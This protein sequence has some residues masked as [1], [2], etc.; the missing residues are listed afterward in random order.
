MDIVASIP[1]L[2][3]SLL[4]LSHSG[5]SASFP[6]EYEESWCVPNLLEMWKLLVIPEENP[7]TM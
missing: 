5:K 6:L 3:T 1:S 4:L 7:A 2:P